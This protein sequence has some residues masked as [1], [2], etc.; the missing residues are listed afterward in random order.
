MRWKIRMLK[1]AKA[2]FDAL[3]GSQ[4]SIV[5]K[6]L[7]K[8]SKNPLPATEG[9]YGKPLGSHNDSNLTGLLK[10]K[11]KKYGIRI[12]YKI[13]KCKETMVIVVI[14]MRSDGDAYDT[15]N[16]RMHGYQGTDALDV[17]TEK[18]TDENTEPGGA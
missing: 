17:A 4:K 7:I 18:I 16:S 15:A 9:G 10:V 6:A 5:R 13:F 11:L 8:V 2:D 1:E 12:V 14:G 3:D